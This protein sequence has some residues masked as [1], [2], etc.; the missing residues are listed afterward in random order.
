MELKGK[1]TVV[2]G[3]GKT[4][5]AL[6]RFL[7]DRG[8]QVT[9]T[10][11]R[12]AHLMETVAGRMNRLPITLKLGG[13][14]EKILET[15][16]LVV[17]SPGVPHT[18]A[19]LSF[20]H[21]HNIPVIGEIELA[22]RFVEEPVVAITG[23]NGKSTTTRL[24]GRM[25]EHSGKSV[26]LGGNLG[27]PL[28]EYVSENKRAD[29]VV[30]EVSSFQ[31]DTIIHFRPH[32]GVLLNITA[33]HMDR[34]DTFDAYA[35]SKA[36]LFENQLS[37][38]TAVVNA[39]DATVTRVTKNIK[40]RRCLF[41]AKAPADCSAV[42][43]ESGVLIHTPWAG[44]IVINKNMV[45]LTGRHNLENTAAA[46]LAAL[47][48]GGNEAGILSAL[49]GFVPDPHRLAHVATVN[50]V[51]Y[52]DDSKGTNVDAVVRAVEALEGPVVL[53]AGGRDKFGGY[54]ALRDPVKKNVKALI[55]MGEAAEA[56]ARSLGDLVETW[57]AGSMAEAVKTAAGIAEPG[58]KVLLSPAC[59]SFDMYENY[60]A[61]GD[62]FA[63]AVI[64]MEKKAI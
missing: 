62:D 60:A 46:A 34:Y 9:V 39:G 52:Y 47:A 33:D 58:D 14:D 59:A 43:S 6:V 50:G 1:H 21:K 8:A 18:L 12:P 13:H 37:M 4:G 53:I 54:E 57:H 55:V 38:D 49:A 45:P 15:A 48:A 5:E 61:R 36:R 63:S 10:D 2:F 56:I 11:S 25:L 64:S 27:Q 35:R 16:D 23:T 40:S 19:C 24:V 30:V 42:V 17:I 29:V 7:L 44:R 51:P 31:L 3:L 28:I 20:A 26:F 32:V 22:G 41:N